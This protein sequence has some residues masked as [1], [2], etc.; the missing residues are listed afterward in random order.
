VDLHLTQESTLGLD[1][2]EHQDGEGNADGGVDTVLDRREDGH[3]DPDKKDQDIKRRH[4]PE[5]IDG[6]RRGDQVTNSV[7]DDRR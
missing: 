6:I 5:L 7:D 1:D 3:D 4:A 2:P